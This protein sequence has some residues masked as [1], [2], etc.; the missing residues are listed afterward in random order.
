MLN[1]GLV[2]P[3]AVADD[4]RDDGR[5]FVDA[6]PAAAAA[7]GDGDIGVGTLDDGGGLVAP[8]ELR[9]E[10]ARLRSTPVPHELTD[11]A[12]AARGSRAAASLQ[13]P[14]TAL[15]EVDLRR[16]SARARAEIATS[17]GAKSPTDPMREPRRRSPPAPSV[18]AR[19]AST[20]PTEPRAPTE[21]V[22]PRLHASTRDSSPR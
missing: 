10:A 17:S 11:V 15:P 19:R 1:S 2:R 21:G 5:R 16:K 13:L 3:P 12:P 14:S 6:A 9:S 7:S 4:R 8:H 20:A 18:E 22:E